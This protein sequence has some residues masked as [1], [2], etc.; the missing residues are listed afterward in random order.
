MVSS[1]GMNAGM[2]ARPTRKLKSQTLNRIGPMM[3]RDH[4]ITVEDIVREVDGVGETAHQTC[5]ESWSA[6]D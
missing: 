1:L 5:V 6:R 2:D 4:L 3:T